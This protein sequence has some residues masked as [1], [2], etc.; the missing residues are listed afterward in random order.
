MLRLSLDPR[1]SEAT[2]VPAREL[3]LIS[4]AQRGDISAFNQLVRAYQEPVYRLA[5]HVLDDAAAAEQATQNAFE[6]AY[7]TIKHWKGEELKLWLLRIA[8]L[9]CKHRKRTVRFRAPH[10]GSFAP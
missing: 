4:A 8:V 7:R 2:N 10:A 6:S 1:T 9:Q 5:F 3:D